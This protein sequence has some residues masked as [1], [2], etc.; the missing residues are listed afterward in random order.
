[1]STPAEYLNPGLAGYGIYQGATSSNPL[2]QARAAV[3]AAKLGN[4]LYS[5]ASGAG[6]PASGSVSGDINTGATGALDA[7]GVYQGLQQGGWQGDTRAGA[8]ALQGAG[9][10][11][12]N[13]ALSTAGGALLVPLDL[14]N[15]INSYQSG[16]T[17]SD[18]MSGA[19]TGAA[20]G[21]I[22]PGI[23]TA[24]G[25]LVGGA[26]GAL[27][28]A[29][30]PGK[31]D[32]ETSDVQNVINA[33]S[34]NQ[35]N[36]GVAA[37]VQ[38]P[39][40]QLA[41]L[42]DE[43]SSTLPEY[44]Q[45]GRMGEQS[46][47]NDMVD[48][49]NQAVE[50]NPSL[51]SDPNAVYSQ[52]VAPWVNSMGSGYN[53]V[54]ST[55]AA[56][57][58][59]LLEDMTQQ[60]LS[61]NAATDWAAVGGDDP[62]ANIYQNSPI[63]AAAQPAAPAAPVASQVNSIGGKGD[64]QRQAKGG[65]VD[66]GDVR[67]KLKKLYE[68]S[69]ASR[70]R[71]YDDGGYVSYFTPSTP[72]SLMYDSPSSS[73]INYEP[74]SLDNTNF[75]SSLSDE[76]APLT[77]S[78]AVSSIGN[79]SGLSQGSVLGSGGALSGLGSALGVSSMGQLVQQ[80]GALAP[81]LAAALGGNKTASAPATPSGYGAIPSIAT[82]TNTRS[83]T[84][85][86]VANWYTY[87][88]GP[89]QSFFSN[90]QLPNIPGVSPAQSSPTGSSTASTQPSTP[91]TVAPPTGTA[92]NPG[93]T[94]NTQ[95]VVGPRPTLNARGGSFNSAQG[96]SYVGDPGHGDG[97]SDDIDAKLS[98]GE[99][100]MDAGTVSMLG[101]GSNEAGSRALDQLRQRVRKHAGK[102]LVKGK[103]FM[104]A[105]APESYLQGGKQS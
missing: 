93:A 4:N 47:T 42:M 10:L 21:S 68:G 67:N 83:Y 40:L 53:N 61:G 52:V 79:Q 62:F 75:N 49:I 64:V 87:G 26:A 8:S 19:E 45:F 17:G 3:S 95:P 103:Q 70:T 78:Q 16:N 2:A 11:A 28:S 100:V 41:G 25:G 30:G 46:F 35:N 1:M 6:T 77:G 12:G 63:Q 98:G 43:R 69:F 101:N 48:K 37:S 99:Y 96:D 7:L 22:I 39:Y 14:Y 60:Y 23:G 54:G 74:P 66:S 13:S 104:K 90:N 15:E 102:Q 73:D 32:A 76:T 59:G 24:I 55:Y 88:E 65:I 85:P 94:S 34:A 91:V 18:A 89:E 97:T 36:S 56:T 38:D 86:N 81:L 80:Y 20:I 31:T 51:A 44:Q 58:Q 92:A 5:N 29:F 84:Q 82:P 9:L 27:A 105:K 72:Y 33:T 71:H 50:A 57:N